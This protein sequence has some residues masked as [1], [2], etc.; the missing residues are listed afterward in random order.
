MIDGNP[1]QSTSRP[2]FSSFDSFLVVAALVLAFQSLG[3]ILT[4]PLHIPLN[5]NEGWNAVLDARAVT[6]GAGPLYPPSDS[7]LFD[8]YPPLGFYVVGALG[9]Y[10]FGDMIVAGRLVALLS[11]SG[12]AWLIA[13]CVRRL[14]GDWRGGMAAGLLLLLFINTYFQKYVAVDDP[15]W[16]AHA[17]M[18]AGLAVVL[19]GGNL[20][21]ARLV[22]GALL[23]TTGAFVKHNLVALPLAVTIWLFC[24]DR[25]AGLIW[26]AA[27]MIG[28][29]AGLGITAALHG[30]AAFDDILFHHRVFR[31]GL[32][33]YADHDLEP[34]LPMAAAAFVPL[35]VT[36]KRDPA[37]SANALFLALFA[38]T[39]L[40]TGIA[41]RTGE[42]VYY[43]AHFETLIA[44]CLGFGVAV[45]RASGTPIRWRRHA[46]APVALCCF[47]AL[48]LIG[49]WPWHLPRA[50]NDISD[51]RARAQAWQPVI[52]QIA[53][54]RGPV[55]CLM[56]SLCWWAG[57]PSAIDMFNLSEESVLAGAAPAEFRAA[58]A[59]QDFA[60]IQDDPKSFIHNDAVSRLGHDPIMTLFA[61]GYAPVAHGPDHT[62]LLAPVR[63]AARD[64]PSSAVAVERN[65][66][67]L[68][69]HLLIRSR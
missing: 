33:K 24:L 41:Q 52:A 25:R 9:R 21:V 36:W 22:A 50:W 46:I 11:L 16:L 17:I 60:M 47:A 29:G 65:P 1:G 69:T 30:R 19:R 63:A 48:P 39:A 68:T 6:P 64:S 27:A 58:V 38:A 42:G 34:M 61:D 59:R 4:I 12:A 5:Y 67:Q 57:K 51:R 66:E 14:G 40:V 54:T 18:L 7:F 15:Q 26:C 23:I 37:R 32:M 13:L 45:S 44:V 8:N 35:Y 28:L 49:A 53:A 55:G 3:P 20:P 2:G 62:V 43:N 31:L 10:V 56:I